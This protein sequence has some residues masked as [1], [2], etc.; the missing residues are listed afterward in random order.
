MPDRCRLLTVLF[1]VLLATGSTLARPSTFAAARPQEAAVDASTRRRIEE[2]CR[3]LLLGLI[4]ERGLPGASAAMVFADA[5]ELAIPVGFAD[6]EA[7]RDMTA[8]DRLLAGSI[9]K[10]Y[11]TAAAHHLMHAGKL[12]LDDKAA[13]YFEGAG[14][15]ARIPNAQEITILHLLRHQT[16]IPRHVMKEEF[17]EALLEDRDRVWEPEELLSFVFDDQPL[18][19]A[20]E[21]W[22]YA[23]TNYIVLGMIIEAISQ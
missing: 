18:F 20:G 19:P 7:E 14:W 17:W 15:F 13:E 9:G 1:A 22:A 8:H 6:A 11:V 4:E 12:S 21:G 16:G 5:S 10:T 23:D 3:S 2:R